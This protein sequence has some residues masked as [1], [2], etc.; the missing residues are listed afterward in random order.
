MNMV[1]SYFN[2]I[3]VRLEHKVQQEA[4][5]Y[6]EFQFH[7]GTIRT[8]CW[9]RVNSVEKKFNSIKVRLERLFDLLL[10]LCLPYFNSIKVRLEPARRL[11][12]I[13]VGL[14]QF[15]KGTIRTICLSIMTKFVI[16]F[17]SIK[18]RLEHSLLMLKMFCVLI[19]IP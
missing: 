3:K 13:L 15:H 7:K 1:L 18:V 8:W 9:S 2:S 16:Y 6:C 17:N 12:S 5:L 19:S 4:V 14:F 10:C 11:R